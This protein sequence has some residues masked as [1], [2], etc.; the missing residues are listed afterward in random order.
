MFRRLMSGFLAVCAIVCAVV[1]LCASASALVGA[2][3]WEVNSLSNPTDLPPGGHGFIDV[4]VNNVGSVTS[5]GT[6]MITDTLPAGVRGVSSFGWVCNGATPDV[7]TQELSFAIEVM[8]GLPNVALEVEVEPGAAEGAVPNVVEVSGGGA[9]V[10]ASGTDLLRIGS[11]EAGFGFSRAG[12]WFTN[13]D[14]TF[15]TQAGSH[16]YELTTNLDLNTNSEGQPANREELRNVTV[17]LPPGLIGN[18][19]AVPRCPRQQ[20]DDQECPPASQVGIL[21]A[22]ASSGSPRGAVPLTFPV[23]DLVPPAGVTAQFGFDLSGIPGFIDAGVRSGGDYG[24]TV[25]LAN[26]PNRQIVW[27]RVTFWGVPADPRHDSERWAG[28]CNPENPFNKVQSSGCG[29]G[30]PAVPLLTLPTVCAGP[31]A[32]LAAGNTWSSV[33]QEAFTQF[34]TSDEDD[35]PSAITGCE[36]LGF[37]PSIAVAPDTMQAG[38]PAGL[39]VDVRIPQGGL[40]SPESLA[41]ADV[42][43]ATVMLPEGIVLNPARAAGLQFCPEAEDAV[44]SEAAPSCPA[45]S[46]IGTAQILTPLLSK[47]LEGAIYVLPSAPPDVRLLLAA[48]GEGVNVKLVGQTHLDP[49]T[50]RLT[51]TFSE[52]PQLPFTELK[53][54]FDGGPQASVVTPA[55]C[56]AYT[57]TSDFTPWSTPVTADAFP[58]SG[59]AV[60]SGIG[61]GAC[62]GLSFTP[63][64]TAGSTNSQAGAFSPFSVTLSRQDQEQ[65]LSGIGVT[66]PPGLLGI[67]K[68]VERCPEPQANQGTC[69][70]GSLIGSTTVAV[71]PGPDP[72]YVQGGQVFLTGPYKGA[73]F[74]LSIVVPAVAG[75]FNLGN[76]IVRAAVSVDPHT[77]QITVTSDPLPRMLDGVPLDV[78]TVNVTIDRQSFMF[79]PTDCNP[80]AVTGSIASTQGTV[81]EVSSRFQ[82]ANCA[83]LAFTPSFKVSTQAKTSKQN[84]ASLTVKG[85]LPSGNANLHSVAVVLPKQL[86]ARL[87]TIQQA[88][89]EATFAANPAS[90]PA[91]SDIGVATATTP[92]LATPVTGPAYLV[93]HGGAAFPDVVLILQGEGVTLDV[94]GSIDIKK[95]IT[96]SDFA[97]IPDAPISSFTLTLPEGPHSGLAAV[98][99]AKAKGSLCGTSLTM[100]FTMIGQNDAQITQDEKIAVTGCPVPVRKAHGKKKTKAKTRKGSKKKAK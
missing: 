42:K 40:E 96:S 76:V 32:F 98:V 45:A 55:A 39:S 74:G 18:P 12:A 97:T 60:E 48:S 24:V 56:G 62:S 29:S 68:G 17:E 100:P 16:P 88:C 64:F 5:N 66:A 83:A 20:F 21:Q 3:G 2:P 51:T 78:R 9:P 92:V 44:G 23:L 94:L 57:T 1:V 59:F 95:G 79:N 10:A 8:H 41:E 36:H 11:S 67:L 81:A 6:I 30:S 37:E 91:G 73:Q 33:S 47:P 19:T 84:G 27:S 65:N 89:P 72:L 77:A 99:P 34:T 69:G 38:A 28:K 52:T 93:S 25:H 43:D 53:L 58:S 15:G 4:N 75:P 46:R 7:C 50:G 82:A 87:T 35:V 13:A 61:G 31:L 14:G 71:G 90:C 85:T 54:T 63:A 80:L 49:T 22:G 26:V 70:A 86:P